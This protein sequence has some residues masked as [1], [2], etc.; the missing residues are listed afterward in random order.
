MSTHSRTFGTPLRIL[1]VGLLCSSSAVLCGNSACDGVGGYDPPEPDLGLDMNV[2][3]D[4]QVTPPEED[5]M[6]SPEDMGEDMEADMATPE[7]IG[8]AHV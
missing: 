1:M 6:P 5:M 4:M 2:E 8:R 3:Q 7:E